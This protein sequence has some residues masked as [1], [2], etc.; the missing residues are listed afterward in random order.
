M[1]S[2]ITS[3]P[4]LPFDLFMDRIK[5]S[6]VKSDTVLIPERVDTVYLPGKTVTKWKT[7]YVSTHSKPRG[8]CIMP[9]PNHEKS[10][11]MVREEKTK[12]RTDSVYQIKDKITLSVNN[13]VVYS[14]ENDNH[15]TS[16]TP[17]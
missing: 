2:E 5:N 13:N 11:S 9:M 10:Q 7:R 16:V 1:A 8:S 3:R 6:Q 17:Q 14:S 4:A 12:E 15:S